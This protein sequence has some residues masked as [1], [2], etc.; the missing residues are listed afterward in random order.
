M[1]HSQPV[2]QV[3]RHKAQGSR[4]KGNE[5]NKKDRVMARVVVGKV[6]KDLFERGLYLPSGTAMTE[7]DIDRVV[8]V[9]LNCKRS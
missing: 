7:E 2:F 9:I 8:E 6:A 3:A 5:Q 1:M 4:R